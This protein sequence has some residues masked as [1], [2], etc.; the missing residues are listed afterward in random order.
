LFHSW[1]FSFLVLKIV[2]MNIPSFTSTID[3]KTATNTKK[4]QQSKRRTGN[5]SLD[6]F[7]SKEGWLSKNC[8]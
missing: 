1:W 3:Q 7:S 8:V 4:N 5:G 6:F 2:P